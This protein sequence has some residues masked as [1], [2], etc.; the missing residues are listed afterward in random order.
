[1]GVRFPSPVPEY[2]NVSEIRTRLDSLKFNYDAEQL[3]LGN[4]IDEALKVC[5]EAEREG[6]IFM[7]VQMIAKLQFIE[8]V[9]NG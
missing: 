3:T 9:L 7:D 5:D 1:M 6:G 4:F 2:P 8:K